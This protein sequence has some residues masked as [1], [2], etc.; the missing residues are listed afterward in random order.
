MSALHRCITAVR[1]MSIDTD[2][3]L[4]DPAVLATSECSSRSARIGQCRLMNPVVSLCLGL[5]LAMA[6]SPSQAAVAP[7]PPAEQAPEPSSQPECQSAS[8]CLREAE[9]KENA[10]DHAGAG[11]YYSNAFERLR[12]KQGANEGARIAMFC[13]EAY[14]VAF[15]V[16]GDVA[17]LDAADACLKRWLER[18]GPDSKATL[19]ASVKTMLKQ[20]E[21]VHAPLKDAEAARLVGDRTRDAELSKQAIEAMK[22]QQRPWS[23]VALLVARRADADIAVFDEERTKAKVDEDDLQKLEDTKRLLEEWRKQR[24]ADDDSDVGPLIDRRLVEIQARIDEATRT[25]P[26]IDE[27]TTEI[28]TKGVGPVV[29]PEQPLEPPRK[30]VTAITLLS[31]GGVVAAAGAAMLGEGVAFS[32]VARRRGDAEEAKADELQQQYGSSYPRDEFDADL[33]RYRDEARAR[34]LGLIAGGA[35]LLAGGLA[36]GIVGAVLLAKRSR[37]KGPGAREKLVLI[38]AVSRSQLQLSLTARF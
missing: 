23:A 22:V 30:R 9:T 2:D 16:D 14:R 26:P 12:A 32:S 21:E 1:L 29:E 11:Q 4:L 3:P 36:S 27:T 34:N 24:P 31:V 25:P 5:A 10:G 35:V 28:E 18:A 19:G 17:H 38:P 15:D 7:E 20:L 6:P 13:A 37:A 33:Q 8:E